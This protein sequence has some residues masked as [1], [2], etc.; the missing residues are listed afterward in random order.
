MSKKVQWNQDF[1]TWLKILYQNFIR[2][3]KIKTSDE[4]LP[5]QSDVNKSQRKN[6]YEFS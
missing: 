5:S 3:L 1:H 2:F 4:L 6:N